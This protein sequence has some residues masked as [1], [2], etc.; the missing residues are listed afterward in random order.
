VFDL[1][2]A[3]VVPQKVSV[4]LTV[5][6]VM[7][8]GDYDNYPGWVECTLLDALGE[9]HTFVEKIPIV[10]PDDDLAPKVAFLDCILERATLSTSN[11]R[12]LHVSSKKPWDVESITG[13]F[14]FVVT[15]AQLESTLTQ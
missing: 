12:L 7:Q 9:S 4:K 8:G 2:G 10:C 15:E 13:R 11:Q 6:K 1:V 14:E 5:V 3:G